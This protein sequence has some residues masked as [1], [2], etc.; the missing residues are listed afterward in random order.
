ML[1]PQSHSRKSHT[2]DFNFL[3]CVRARHS[4]MPFYASEMDHERHVYAS[5]FT[6]I[7]FFISF[8]QNEII[9]IQEHCNAM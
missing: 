8:R 6:L 5:S 3:T 1:K 2:H 4:T 9:I 7:F